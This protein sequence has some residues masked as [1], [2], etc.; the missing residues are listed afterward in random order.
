MIRGDIMKSERK[1]YLVED[2]EVCDTL[3]HIKN[4]SEEQG[5][6]DYFLIGYS[7]TKGDKFKDVVTGRIVENSGSDS[8][9]SLRR[10][11]NNGCGGSDLAVEYM[12]IF[13]EF[14]PSIC[15]EILASIIEHKL[16]KPIIDIKD[17][18]F[19][20]DRIN[21]EME[22]NMEAFKSNEA[23]RLSKKGQLEAYSVKDSEREF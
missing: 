11:R 2:L 19:I 18:K 13:R 1:K 14:K 9:I 6:E 5:Q 8:L 3:D 17:I 21:W 12:T 20:K 16:G 10:F 7:N 23:E 22:K 15:Q 4:E